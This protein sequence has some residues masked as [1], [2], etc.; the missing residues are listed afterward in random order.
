MT[1]TATKIR[2]DYLKKLAELAGLDQ[3]SMMKE[4]EYLIDHRLAELA[5][6]E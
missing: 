5:K 1:Y 3:R 6:P 2:R 4:L